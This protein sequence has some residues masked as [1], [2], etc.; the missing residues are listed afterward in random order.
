MD[1]FNTNNDDNDHIAD[2]TDKTIT[3]GHN[4][5]DQDPAVTREDMDFSNTSNDDNDHIDDDT[6]KTITNGQNDNTDP[7]TNHDNAP[8]DTMDFYTTDTDTTT[9]NAASCLNTDTAN[10]T[11]LLPAIGID[12]RLR[13]STDSKWNSSPWSRV[14]YK[15]KT[16]T[17][18]INRTNTLSIGRT[19]TIDAPSPKFSDTSNDNAMDTAEDCNDENHHSRD[20]QH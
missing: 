18:L 20:I 12:N 9:D 1:F 19:D 11:R 6:D 13:Y 8:S 5:K 10:K 15:K 7:M 4:D 2:N 3:N 16:K 14:S 17:R